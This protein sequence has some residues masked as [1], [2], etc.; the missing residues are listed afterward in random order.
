LS[1][2]SLSIPCTCNTRLPLE[3]DTSTMLV[4]LWHYEP[5]SP[6]RNLD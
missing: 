5:I 4:L 3:M 6:A 2:H 1:V